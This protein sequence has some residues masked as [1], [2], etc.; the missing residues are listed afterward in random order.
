MSSSG[1]EKSLIL[2][3][4]LVIDQPRQSTAGKDREGG[5]K[6]TRKKAELYSKTT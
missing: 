6:K 2:R 5:M 1:C 4:F 3:E